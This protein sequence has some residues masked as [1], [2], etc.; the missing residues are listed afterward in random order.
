MKLSK[1]N[2]LLLISALLFLMVVFFL[3]EY[4]RKPADVTG[5]EPAAK[6]T[7]ADL[8]DLYTSDETKANSLFLDKTIQVKGTIAE[9]INQ[10]DTMVNVLLG[11]TNALH[12]VSC[13]L[14]KRHLNN[15]K[16]YTTGGQIIIK[17]IC[18]GFLID[19]ELNRCVIVDNSKQ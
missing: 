16:N 6:T 17:G 15:I 3:K 9:I 11:D 2:I 18:T 5:I 13:L 10:K 8:V 12:K 4:F 1:K 14:D 7:V 19:V